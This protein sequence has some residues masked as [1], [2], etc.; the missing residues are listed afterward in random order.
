MG[1]L[2]R[3]AIGFLLIVGCSFACAE[4]PDVAQPINE[5]A[6]V[7]AVL[8]GTDLIDISALDIRPLDSSAIDGRYTAEQGGAELALIVTQNGNQW[9][10]E[11][12]YSEPELVA[13]VRT[14]QAKMQEGMLV[15]SGED[16]F[17]KGT[18]DGLLVLEL[19]SGLDSIPASYWT[20][21]LRQ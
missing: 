16:L 11:R 14:Y 19:Q 10:I 9:A 7:E 5:A 2:G 6:K 15:S 18:S 12:T 4:R 8:D 20:H 1:R 13:E 21:Y 17:A 3:T